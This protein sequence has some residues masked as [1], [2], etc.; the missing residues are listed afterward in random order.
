MAFN[1]VPVNG[2]PQIKDLEKLDAIAQQIENMPTYTSADRAFLDEW[3]SKL[4]DLAEDVSVLET[5]KA[6]QITIAPFFSAETAYDQGDLVYY[7]GLTYRCVNAH[8]GEWDADDFVATTIANEISKI[9]IEKVTITDTTNSSGVLTPATSIS[10]SSY[11]VLSASCSGSN[12]AIPF[13]AS[14]DNTWRFLIVNTSLQPTS[15]EEVTV[16]YNRKAI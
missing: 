4:P 10:P 6:N 2:W 15:S 7:N 8:D 14:S 5:T 12:L 9:Q 16:T 3:E 13:I 11:E 1:N